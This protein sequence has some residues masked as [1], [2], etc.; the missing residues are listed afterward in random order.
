[1]TPAPHIDHLSKIFLDPYGL[2]DILKECADM[3]PD[4]FWEFWST[5]F[6]LV[7]Q[8]LCGGIIC[9]E[10]STDEENEWCGMNNDSFVGPTPEPEVAVADEMNVDWR[11][12]DAMRGKKRT[13]KDMITRKKKIVLLGATYFWANKRI[14]TRAPKKKYNYR[15]VKSMANDHFEVNCDFSKLLANFPGLKHEWVHIE[16]MPDSPYYDPEYD[17]D[18]EMTDA[19]TPEPYRGLGKR[20]RGGESG[21]KN[22]QRGELFERRYLTAVSPKDAGKYIRSPDGVLGI[23]VYRLRNEAASL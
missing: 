15:V 19:L 21:L 9:P 23:P 14:R 12:A 13:R 17:P 10:C 7:D 1:M 5:P 22:K 8:C 4:T 11:A 18:T 6:V 16:D 20:R 3:S 2:R